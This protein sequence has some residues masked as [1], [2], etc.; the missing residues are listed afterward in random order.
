MREKSCFWGRLALALVFATAVIGCDDEQLIREK[1]P[2]EKSTAQR[3]NSWADQTSSAGITHSVANDGVVTVTVGGTAE[4]LQNRW[5][6]NANY[7]YT[8]QKDATY[9]YKFEA[10]TAQGS[11]N[12]TLT[13]EY[14]GFG[15][16]LGTAGPPYL[17]TAQVI[18][19]ERKEYAI[20]GTITGD[21]PT[22]SGVSFLD[23][24]CAD[25]LG[26]F[27]VKVISITKN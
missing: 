2:E 18:T 11:G 7:E 15:I 9:I 19:E 14:Y 27:Y 22:N 17:T 5:K 16:G 13:V 6:A 4:T 26:T 23:F 21:P 8:V 20:T 1:T 24:Q 25:Q 3:W 12:R 10:W